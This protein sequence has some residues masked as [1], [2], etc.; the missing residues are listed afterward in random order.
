M[1][2][3][4]VLVFYFLMEQKSLHKHLTLEEF[5][6]Q[7][8]SSLSRSPFT[9]SKVA[10]WM[11]WRFLAL[12]RAEE[13]Q[14]KK[15]WGISR[16]ATFCRSNLHFFSCGVWRK[17][18]ALELGSENRQNYIGMMRISSWNSL[19]SRKCFLLMITSHPGKCGGIFPAKSKLWI[20]HHPIRGDSIG[21][22]L[23][24][25]LHACMCDSRMFFFLLRK[26]FLVFL[27]EIWKT[28]GGNE[29][30]FSAVYFPRF[31]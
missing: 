14:Q 25:R 16:F 27:R 17:W 28:Q 21:F 15:C 20:F 19:Q 11:G 10:V 6:L 18:S 22:T 4:Q 1:R 26:N 7:L 24:R 3:E 29:M 13:Q 8:F 23:R 12:E 5:S 30:I 9:H 31:V 2:P